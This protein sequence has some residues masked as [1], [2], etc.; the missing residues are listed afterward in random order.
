L[1]VI[2]GLSGS[3]KTTYT[4]SLTERGWTALNHDLIVGHGLV[5]NDLE[6]AWG[7][8]FQQAG[9]PTVEPFLRRAA[10]WPQP[11]VLEFGFPIQLLPMVVDL[12]DAGASIWWFDGDRPAAQ[13]A[14]RERNA[15]RA[16]PYPDAA[17]RNYVDSVDLNWASICQV[18]GS[19]IIRVIGPGPWHLHRRR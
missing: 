5:S 8:T 13:Q 15:T 6:Q 10:E 19:N 9:A 1:L 16:E 2:S 17:W 14:W 12:R 11:V 4:D 7:S 3:G 18:F